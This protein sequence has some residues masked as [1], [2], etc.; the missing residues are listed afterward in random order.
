VTR[1]DWVKTNTGLCAIISWFFI[2]L[3]LLR[4]TFFLGLDGL[5]SVASLKEIFV[6][7]KVGSY[8]CLLKL[9]ATVI[10]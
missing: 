1:I 8:S 7:A 3:I 9:H 10:R 6:N 4:H 5:P 2:L